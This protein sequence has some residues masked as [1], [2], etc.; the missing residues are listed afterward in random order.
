TRHHPR[1]R[2]FPYTTLFRSLEQARVQLVVLIPDELLV[3]Q[4]DAVEDRAAIAPERHRVNQASL[5]GADAEVGVPDPE[6]MRQADGQGA[7]DR[8]STRLNSSHDQSSYA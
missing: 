1:T 6:R 7:R 4:P 3:E 5:R 8:K 2:L